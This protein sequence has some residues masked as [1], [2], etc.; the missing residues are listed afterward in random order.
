MS[1][2]KSIFSDTRT[3]I[4]ELTHD[5]YTDLVNNKNDVK[6]SKENFENLLASESGNLYNDNYHS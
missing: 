4:G 2:I 1:G 3:Q 5:T 6:I